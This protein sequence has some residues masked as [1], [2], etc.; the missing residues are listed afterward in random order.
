MFRSTLRWQNSL[1]LRAAQKMG[2]RCPT[3]IYNHDFEDITPLSP[4]QSKQLFKPA[5]KALTS[6]YY[7]SPPSLDLAAY[8]EFLSGAKM[9]SF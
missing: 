8:C 2:H 6:H 4:P 5:V 9:L 3:Y 7:A 1:M